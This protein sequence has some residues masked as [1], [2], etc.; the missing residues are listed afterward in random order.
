MAGCGH[1]LE[2]RAEDDMINYKGHRSESEGGGIMF[3]KGGR[4]PSRGILAGTREKS[5]PKLET[6]FDR[7]FEEV[8]FHQ[9]QV[10]SLSCLVTQYVSALFQ[11]MSKIV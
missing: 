2:V 10:H 5:E 11:L 3:E 6:K 9:T 4:A 8:I 1:C 7:L